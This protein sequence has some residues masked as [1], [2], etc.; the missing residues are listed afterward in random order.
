ML[1]KVFSVTPGSNGFAASAPL[2]SA[3]KLTNVFEVPAVALHFQP[4]FHPES[5]SNGH[6]K[7]RERPAS[8]RRL[9]AVP[10]LV[11]PVHVPCFLEP[12]TTHLS[13]PRLRSLTCREHP[14]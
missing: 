10:L 6:A 9:L 4:A 2:A 11:R 7:E 1:A 8:A 3:N 13:P 14:H 12:R 5:N